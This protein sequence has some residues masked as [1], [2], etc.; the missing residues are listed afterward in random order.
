[1][2]MVGIYLL[3]DQSESRL[4][5]PRVTELQIEIPRDWWPIKKEYQ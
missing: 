5:P 2:K 1:M 3:F 4:V